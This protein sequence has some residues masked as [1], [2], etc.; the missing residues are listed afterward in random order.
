MLLRPTTSQFFGTKIVVETK[1][2]GL[3]Q[4]IS[5]LK[6]VST[7]GERSPSDTKEERHSGDDAPLRLISLPL[8]KRGGYGMSNRWL[9]KTTDPAGK[10]FRKVFLKMGTVTIRCSCSIH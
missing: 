3:I 7:A 6:Q 9:V 8:L 10:E 2:L 4:Q 1:N 5:T